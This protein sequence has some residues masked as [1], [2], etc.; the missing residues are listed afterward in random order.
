MSKFADFFAEFDTRL[1]EFEILNYGVSMTTL[2]EV[3]LSVNGYKGND[4][5]IK[6]SQQRRTSSI[7]EDDPR[8]LLT[9]KDNDDQFGDHSLDKKKAAKAPENMIGHGT[10][11]MSIKALLTKRFNLY[12]RDKC[13]LV[14]ELIVPVILALIGLSLLK[15][16]V[17]TDSPAFTLDTSAYPGP[18][19]VL[20]N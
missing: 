7:N 1:D 9:T 13:G 6:M 15:V 20:F 17:V 2:E 18:Q 5:A 10:L 3:F 16:P 19:R 8:G 4:S 12:K 11:G 14:C